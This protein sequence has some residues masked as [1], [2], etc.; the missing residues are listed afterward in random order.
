[1]PNW[2]PKHTV[3]PVLSLAEV[4]PCLIAGRFK[5]VEF[6]MCDAQ[7]SDLSIMKGAGAALQHVDKVRLRVTRAAW[8]A[9]RRGPAAGPGGD[10]RRN[11]SGV[12][13]RVRRQPANRAAGPAAHQL[14]YGAPGR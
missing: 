1:M 13:P 14:S 10:K 3:V 4:I 7:G 12:D 11:V 2:Q 6:L 9:R 5:H 8:P